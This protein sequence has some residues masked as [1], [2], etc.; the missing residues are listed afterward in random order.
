VTTG[1][2]EEA[3][4]PDNDVP[5]DSGLLGYGVLLWGDRFLRLEGM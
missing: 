1:N 4:S 3:A 2:K 5:E